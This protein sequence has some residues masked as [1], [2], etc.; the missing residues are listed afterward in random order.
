MSKHYT[1]AW[2]RNDSLHRLEMMT[3]D[4]IGKGGAHVHGAVKDN[5]NASLGF[6][7]GC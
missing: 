4:V 1:I 7:S 3:V 5:V 2:R 6:V